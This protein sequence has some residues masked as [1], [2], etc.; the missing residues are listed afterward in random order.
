MNKTVVAVGFVFASLA[1]VGCSG[2]GDSPQPAG[3]INGP[4]IVDP[5]A[6]IGPAN[7]SDG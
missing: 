3:G 1:A 7:D 2:N 4:A 6:E 5:D